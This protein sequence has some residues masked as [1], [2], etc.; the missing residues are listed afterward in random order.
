LIHDVIKVKQLR[1]RKKSKRSDGLVIGIPRTLYY[2][3]YPGLWEAFFGDIGV[4]TV[5]ANRS[6]QKTVERAGLI[7]E[8]E[9]CLPMK[10]FDAHLAELFEHGVDK[11]FV[12][13]ILSGLKGHIACPKLGALPDTATAMLGQEDKVLT[14]DINEDQF[15]LSVSLEK[16]GKMLGVRKQSVRSAIGSSSDILD[17]S[18]AELASSPSEEEKWVLLL[19]HPY[20]LFDDFFSGP[21]IKKLKS[22]DVAVQLV[23]HERREIPHH[24]IK[25]DT[26]SK[27]YRELTNLESHPCLGV[28]QI[29]SFNCGCDSIVGQFYREILK[30]KG[31]PYMSLILDEHMAPAGMETRLEAFVESS[32]W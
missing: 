19:A 21:V 10:M 22:L 32:R 14:V 9:H 7:S 25:W 20:N 28:I 5:V 27:M 2:F 29:S 26:C 13:R 17:K 6:T 30:E 24:P 1:R 23:N 31:I 16:L 3:S 12:P 8:S 15:P 11:L 4:E 18:L